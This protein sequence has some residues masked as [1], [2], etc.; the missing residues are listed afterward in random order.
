MCLCPAAGEESTAYR[1]FVGTVTKEILDSIDGC[2]EGKNCGVSVEVNSCGCI[3][4]KF[5]IRD[6]CSDS[7]AGLSL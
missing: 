6:T 2:E 4:H 1:M 3:N 5:T 7:V